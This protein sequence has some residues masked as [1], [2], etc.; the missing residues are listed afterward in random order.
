ME[1]R[2]IK[3]FISYTHSH[4]K[5]EVRNSFSLKRKREKEKARRSGHLIYR[6][7]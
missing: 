4:A 5:N 3:P 2:S 6:L 1:E 7:N